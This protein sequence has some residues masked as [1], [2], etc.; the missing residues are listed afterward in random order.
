MLIELIT[1]IKIFYIAILGWS[2][3]DI[4]VA[5]CMYAVV[6]FVYPRYALRIV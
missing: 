3:I 1:I 6:L 5:S 4:V 2:F